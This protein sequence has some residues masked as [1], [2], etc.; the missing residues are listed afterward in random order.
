MAIPGL[1]GQIQYALDYCFMGLGQMAVFVHVLCHLFSPCSSSYK[2]KDAGNKGHAEDM[3]TVHK[4][5]HQYITSI[6]GFT[7]DKSIF[8][9]L[10]VIHLL[11]P[12]H[13]HNEFDEDPEQFGRNLQNWK[14][15]IV[16]EDMPV[17]LYPDSG[18]DPD[19]PDKGLLHGPLLVSV[20]VPVIFI[21]IANLFIVL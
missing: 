2:L 12:W 13:L 11:C 4:H 17:F 5:V 18:Y 14:N 16:H 21:C 9:S 19:F 10:T 6:Q 8:N 1:E 20:S 15:I 7:N 3:A